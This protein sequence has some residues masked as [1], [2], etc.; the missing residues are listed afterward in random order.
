M[1][2]LNRGYTTNIN[3][4]LSIPGV[5][6]S[7][8]QLDKP[9]VERRVTLITSLRLFDPQLYFPLSL[10][11][12]CKKTFTRLSTY[13]WFNP[14]Y[15]E[16]ESNTM[17]L[18]EFVKQLSTKQSYE[19]V[20]YPINDLDLK[21]RIQE[22]IE[23]QQSMNCSH[24]IIPTPL[25]IDTED[26]FCEQLKWINASIEFIKNISKPVLISVAFSQTV[27]TQR[28]F[29]ENSLLS[30]IL[31]NL[32]SFNEFSG[33]YITFETTTSQQITD[34]N[35][36]K[37]ILEFSYVLGELYNKEVI[38][39]YT[40]LAGLLGLCVGAKAFGSGYF[41]KEKYLNYEDFIDKEGFGISLPFFFSYSLIGDF[42]SNKDLSK[43]RDKN[44]LHFIE[45]DITKFSTNLYDTLI[46]NQDVQMLTE[47]KES[48]NNVTAAKLHRYELLSQVS[49][50]ISSLP[51]KDRLNLTQKW[52]LNA[53]MK[54]SYL[55]NI[56][57]AKNLTQDFSHIKIWSKCLD[58]FIKKYSLL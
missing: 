27:L 31:D 17:K 43:L 33:Y 24:I 1:F 16:F 9:S 53:D 51:L 36:I 2:L 39:N 35:I 26:A 21:K 25:I 5:I 28:D 30:L 42:L 20:F 22:C 29:E 54:T 41:N 10:K 18:T 13:P 15:D 4:E 57:K 55:L 7:S 48:R 11:N 40:D 19:N 6:F 12:S 37:T 46:K 34:V 56:I 58:D 52:L 50:K 32:S 45:E 23:F 14:N 44:L 38:L 8:A 3:S 47:W 49:S